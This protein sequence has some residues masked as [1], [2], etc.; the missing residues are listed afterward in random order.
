MTWYKGNQLINKTVLLGLVPIMGNQWLFKR[1][2][3][4]HSV[5]S[6]K[7]FKYLI[8]LCESTTTPTHKIMAHFGPNLN[9]KEKYQT[10]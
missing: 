9:E 2:H 10:S 8:Q 3:K 6:Y 7:A 1:S 5:V 4:Y